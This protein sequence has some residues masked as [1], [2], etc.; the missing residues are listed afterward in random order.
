MTNEE[1]RQRIKEIKKD[2]RQIMDGAK[3]SQ[4]RDRGLNYKV[5]WGATL[6][7]LREMADEIGQDYTL[8]VELWKE[9]TRECKILATMI[10]PHSEMTPDL[11]E[12]WMEQTPNVEIAEQAVFNLYQ[13]LNFAS[14]KAF[15]WLSSENILTQTCGYHILSRLFMSKATPSER[16]INEF[17]DQALTALQSDSPI[18]K[19]AAM[20]SIVHFADLG[21][22]YERIAKSA[23]RH[24]G[25]DF[26]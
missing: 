20:Q 26:L 10:M 8:A 6:P 5:N 21:L 11:M 25:A 7:R 17:I 15:V 16:D 23:T 1:A 24:I 22:V 18:L 13:Y 3:A 2:F 14:T 9:N 19:K 12:L 4:M